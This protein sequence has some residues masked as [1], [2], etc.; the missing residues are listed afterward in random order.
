MGVTAVS[1][2]ILELSIDQLFLTQ[3]YQERLWTGQTVAVDGRLISMIADSGSSEAKLGEPPVRRD[4]RRLKVLLAA[5]ATVMLVSTALTW[6]TLALALRNLESVWHDRVE[7][8]EFLYGAVTPFERTV[9][10]VAGEDPDFPETIAR[11]DSAA[12]LSRESWRRY[13]GTT[14][15]DDEARLVDDIIPTM[16]RTHSA[17]DTLTGRM[18]RADTVRVE[19]ARREYLHAVSALSGGIEPL[20]RLQARVTRQMVQAARARHLV[21]RTLLI[22]SVV[23]TIVL[24][25]AALRGARSQGSWRR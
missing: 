23:A 4:Q 3:L 10:S 5:L 12:S 22:G 17:L 11:L 8:L 1:G 19:Y 21:S 16:N 20:I 13:L 7:A 6:G 24:V 9:A 2:A 14:F 15:T 25:V 18:S